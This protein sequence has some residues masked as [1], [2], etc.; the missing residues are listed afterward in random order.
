VTAP[1]TPGFHHARSHLDWAL[2]HAFHN[3]TLPHILHNYDRLSMAH[4]VE[5]RMPL[6]DWRL[7][8]YG[9]SLP[10][11]SKIGG[12]YAKRVLREAM[13]GILPER[14][15]LRR[16]KVGF[17]VPLDQWFNG[18]FRPWVEDVTSSS[19]FLH[20]DLWDG[21][22]LRCFVQEKYRTPPPSPEWGGQG[23]GWTYPDA[24][25]VWR[26][27]H[28]STWLDLFTRPA[29]FASSRPKGN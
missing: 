28:A 4:G 1:A 11:A 16:G 17:N 12:R 20:S 5:V 19:A 18:P 23:G 13:R 21:R 26:Y 7:V 10:D 9:F 2:Y 24:L 22:A 6:M 3:T 25:H 14:I 29:A 15:R 8:V 27:L